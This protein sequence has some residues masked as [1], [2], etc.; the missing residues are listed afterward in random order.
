MVIIKSVKDFIY[1][2]S[3]DKALDVLFVVMFASKV[4]R[5]FAVTNAADLFSLYYFM[6]DYS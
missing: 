2:V 6:L 4:T 3:L 5:P 1:T